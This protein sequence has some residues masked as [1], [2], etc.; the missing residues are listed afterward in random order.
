MGTFW[1][2]ADPEPTVALAGL[3]VVVVD[4]QMASRMVAAKM[5]R[6]LGMEVVGEAEDGKDGVEIVLREQPDLVVMDLFMP[7]VDGLAASRRILNQ[8]SICIVLTTAS[9]SEEYA[10]EARALGCG[11]LKKP[12]II[13]TFGP[14]LAAAYERFVKKHPERSRR[15]A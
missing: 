15:A 5:A 7:V 12:L 2:V 3:R 14:R 11:F 9:Y 4:D 10:E 8:A 6:T 13:E 1:T